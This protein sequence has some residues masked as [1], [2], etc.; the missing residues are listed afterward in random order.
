MKKGLPI[1]LFCILISGCADEHVVG[2]I[3]ITQYV[4]FDIQGDT[5]KSSA[6]YPSYEKKAPLLLLSAESQTIRGVISSYATQSQQPVEIG[7]LRT[8]VISEK[9]AASG[10]SELVDD[11]V[12][13]PQLASNTKL[14]ISKQNP[15]MIL[16]K[17]LK[18]PAFYLSDLIEQNMK[19]GNTPQTNAHTLL[20]QYFGEGQSVYIPL[21]NNDQNGLI[22]MEGVGVF[23]EDKLKL[24]LTNKEGLLLKLLKDKDLSAIY[25][26]K[27]E[28]QSKIYLQI[29]YG[30]RKV[31]LAQDGKAVIS[32]KLFVDINDFS[33]KND[34]QE[35]K[36][37]MGQHFSSEI[38]SM[39]EKFQRNHVDPIGFGDLYRGRQKKWSEQEFHNQTYPNLTFEVNTEIVIIHSG[40]GTIEKSG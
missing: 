2:N 9:L 10:I 21:I 27:T 35:L 7:Q 18:Y 11:L 6:T 22:Q 36:Q 31:S 24:S 37:Q 23:N 34:L 12:Q 39:L 17:T 16:S 32:L 26:F 3:S 19:Y 15:S 38:K 20:D 33:N 1:F 30:K 25:E 4:S 14:V 13:D 29:S 8:I 40:V 5:F 28:Q